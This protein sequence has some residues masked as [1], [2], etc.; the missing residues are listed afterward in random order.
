MANATPTTP[1]D[2]FSSRLEQGMGVAHRKNPGGGAIAL[3]GNTPLEIQN[4][5]KFVVNDIEFLRSDDV[6]V[7]DW[8]LT[9]Y[10]GVA[11]TF[12]VSSDQ[13][14][15][16]AILD[17]GGATDNHGA[18]VQY[19]AAGGAGE[20]LNPSQQHIVAL[21]YNTRISRDLEADWF[22][23]FA[24]TNATVLVAATGALVAT[25][26][27]YMGFHHLADSETISLVQGGVAGTDIVV[28][29]PSSSLY[30][31][32]N[33]QSYWHSWGL[34]VDDNDKM[35]WYVNGDLVGFTQVGDA[36]T[37]GTVTGFAGRSCY[38]F[39]VVN[40]GGASNITVDYV[41]SA[42]ERSRTDIHA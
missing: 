12:A 6:S 4:H 9:G 15:G 1:K 5:R 20:F 23:G 21:E 17:V 25:L 11:E 39:A 24:E 28:A 40:N 18:Q 31:P 38:T 3:F 19:T 35:Y 29:N 37:G 7:T 27:D 36:E 42:T 10:G 22:V 30:V 34:R 33:Q 13:Q 16:I 26:D 41:L 2:Q 8:T 32:T 14:D